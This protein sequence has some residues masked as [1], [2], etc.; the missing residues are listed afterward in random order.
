M[1]LRSEKAA[2]R[3]RALAE[4]LRR[5]VAESRQRRF[6][7]ARRDVARMRRSDGAYPHPRG[8][9][10]LVR[11][12]PER[13][14]S[15]IIEERFEAF[16]LELRQA[17]AELRHDVLALRADVDQILERMATKVELESQ[18]D[19]D[20]VIADGLAAVSTDLRTVNRSIERL[21]QRVLALDLRIT[22][23]ERT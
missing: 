3:V 10:S 17:T 12:H 9:G 6:E 8:G 20:N 18:K 22:A 16:A 23:L 13:D 15:T 2:A 7:L 19:S 14:L 1:E 11:E 21:E 4:R 5:E